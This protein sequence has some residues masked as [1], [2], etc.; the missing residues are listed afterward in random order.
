MCIR[1]RLRIAGGEGDHEAG[2]DDER[3]AEEHGKA[4]FVVPDEPGEESAGE[5]LGV[6][7][8][9]DVARRGV[10]DGDVEAC[11]LYTSIPKER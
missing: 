3:S 8:L 4:G 1:D 7:E 9:G 11:L 5:Q 2:G 6:V 10:L